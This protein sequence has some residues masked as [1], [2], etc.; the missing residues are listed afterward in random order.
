MSSSQIAGWLS[1]LP[2][3]AALCLALLFSAGCA[4]NPIYSTTGK[5]M[6]GYAENYN[7][8]Y[9]LSLADPDMSCS[10]GTAL[11]PLVYSFKTVT[12][13]PYKTGSLLMLLSA[14]CAEEQAWNANLRSL[15][16]ERA[17]N[18]SEAEDAR[19]ESKRWQA[20]TARR[21][22][23]SFHE[24][25]KAYDY[26]YTNPNV[27]CPDL[28][29]DQDEL[30]FM[31]GLLTGLQSIMNDSASGVMVNV[32]RDI[33]P[34]AERAARCLSNKKW[35]GLPDSIRAAVWLLI[36]ATKPSDSPDP[37]VV[38][39]NDSALGAQKGMRAAGALEVVMAENLG[40]DKILA[41][42]IHRFAAAGKTMK[43]WKEY[44]LI[45]HVA[46][47]TVMAVSDRYWTQHYG[48]RTPALR[49]G[50]LKKDSGPSD[51]SLDDLL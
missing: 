46:R 30:T 2:L 44:Q 11:D 45:D 32:P 24:A 33:A 22:L 37:W 38:L 10:M 34:E 5:V 1:R 49:F 47:N 8:P 17:G 7:T 23:E 41:D 21:R 36:P 51:K 14:N 20:I 40:K 35:A 26:D 19:T 6:T 4:V 50:E 3:R 39:K 43:V 18:V 27:E 48:Q 13:T 42:A 12:D 25:M 9:V 15:R 16:A 29:T 31:L 28:D